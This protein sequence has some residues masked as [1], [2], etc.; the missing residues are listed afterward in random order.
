MKKKEIKKLEPMLDYLSNALGEINAGFVLATL[1]DCLKKSTEGVE[2]RVLR[3]MEIKINDYFAYKY[4][5]E[6]EHYVD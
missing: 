5:F 4:D 3:T 2:Q 6:K 1:C